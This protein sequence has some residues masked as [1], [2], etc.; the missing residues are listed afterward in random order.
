V[1]LDAMVRRTEFLRAACVRLGIAE[2]VTV[3][4]ER[5]EAGARDPVL[6]GQF[7]VVTARSFGPPAVTAECGGGF[8]RVGGYL[9]V[10]EPPD[11]REDRWSDP[12]L[13]ELGLERVDARSRRFA[14]LRRVRPLGDRYPRRVGVPTKRPLWR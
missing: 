4:C 9:V 12:G 13:A 11:D 3:V 10:S 1:L 6:R 2:R 5:A 14:L 7:D 8:A